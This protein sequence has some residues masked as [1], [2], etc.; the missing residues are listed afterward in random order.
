MVTEPRYE[1]VLRPLGRHG[2]GRESVPLGSGVGQ[3]TVEGG[4]HVVQE[5][6]A[7]LGD[8]E[9]PRAATEQA[10]GESTLDRVGAAGR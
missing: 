9:E 3:L 8:T 10:R 4:Q 1:P 7:V 6:A 2:P 5:P